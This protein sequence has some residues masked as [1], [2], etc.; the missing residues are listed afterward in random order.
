MIFLFINKTQHISIVFVTVEINPNMEVLLYSKL[1][2]C[3]IFSSLTIGISSIFPLKSELKPVL[4]F[5]TSC[6]DQHLKCRNYILPDYLFLVG[7][8]GGNLSP[9]FVFVFLNKE[10]AIM[11]REN[12]FKICF[13]HH[14]ST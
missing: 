3:T 10:T 4:N 7:C 11:L 13:I 5:F 6:C 8:L 12:V 1:D 9:G 2:L 14:L